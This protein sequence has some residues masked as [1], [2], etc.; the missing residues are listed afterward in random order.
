MTLVQR[1][2]VYIDS[3]VQGA[4]TRQLVIHWAIFIA[5]A[6]VLA[7]CIQFLGNPLRSLSEHAQRAWWIHGPF[8]LILLALIPLFVRNSIKLS[9]RYA[10]PIYQLRKTIRNI[11]EGKPAQRLKFRDGDYWHGLAEE[12]NTMVQQL[13]QGTDNP[14]EPQHET[15]SQG[16]AVEPTTVCNG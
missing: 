5:V 12:F 13:S 7:I 11:A 16:D 10:G 15:A 14:E 2:R 9:N 6:M 4:L 8:F 3:Q 1:K